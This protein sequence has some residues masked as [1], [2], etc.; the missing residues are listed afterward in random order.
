[1]KSANR[2]RTMTLGFCSLVLLAGCGSESS[3]RS[4]VSPDCKPIHETQTISPGVLTVAWWVY[5]PFS[6]LEDGK[7]TGFEGDLMTEIANMECLEVKPIEMPVGS[8]VS[9]VV[10]GRVDTQTGV[11]YRTEERSR[12]VR[13]GA[14]I[15]ADSMALVSRGAALN[16]DDLKGR[17]AGSLIGNLWNDD[18]QKLMGDDLTLYPDL[19]S[20]YA[21]FKAERI[22]VALD[23]APSAHYRL[24]LLN[25]EATVSIPTPDSRVVATEHPGQTNFFTS[26]DNDKLG[27]A[28][29]N[30]IATLRNNG[31]IAALL[32]KY[33]LPE[34][35]GDPG[36]A[37]AFH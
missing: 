19:A 25:I 7:L 30:D 14:P 33:G 8:M 1:M 23:T 16:I 2:L 6:G 32:K 37:D 35:A 26:L 13:L 31:T 11:F 21:D 34:A 4:S 28:M 3:T 27:V 5:P 9:A 24:G 12:I 10:A 15:L 20:L 22:S 18:L 36:P 29:D 17:R